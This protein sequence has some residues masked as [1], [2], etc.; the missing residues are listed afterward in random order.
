MNIARL[1]GLEETPDDPVAVTARA[2]AH[3]HYAEMEAR[4]ADGVKA[5]REWLAGAYSFADIGFFMAQFYGERKGA[6]MG[7]ATP[8]LL[9]WRA[10]ML[11]RPAV[12]TV[13]G[14]M[15][16]WL[17]SEGRASPA[18]IADAVAEA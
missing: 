16:A 17:L 1:F 3:G 11:T 9:E 2:N 15:G 5:G 18:Y 7:A 4:L 13:I 8:L 12:R 14:R 10:R 6:V